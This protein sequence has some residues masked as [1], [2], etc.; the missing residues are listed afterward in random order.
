MKLRNIILL[1]LTFM[2]CAAAPAFAGEPDY[3]CYIG[4]WRTEQTSGTQSSLEIIDA[5]DNYMA[6]SFQYGQFAVTINNA[7]I[8]GRNVYGNYREAWEGGEF[9]VS[10][11]ITLNLGNNS[12][13]VNWE[14]YENGRGPSYSSFMFYNSRFVYREK[15]SAPKITEPPAPTPEPTPAYFDTSKSSIDYTKYLGSY[16][17]VEGDNVT[18]LTIKKIENETLDFECMCISSGSVVPM[19]YS[20]GRFKSETTAKS[21]GACEIGGR[22]SNIEY[23]F[24]FNEKSVQFKWWDGDFLTFSLSP[25]ERIQGLKQLWKYKINS[26]KSEIPVDDI[27]EESVAKPQEQQSSEVKQ[28]EGTQLSDN[29]LEEYILWFSSERE[30]TEND[31]ARH[32]DR[33]LTLIRNEIY[34]RHGRK[35]LTSWIQEYF[36]GCSWY[37]VNPDYNYDNEDSMLTALERHNLQVIV[38]YENSL[39]Q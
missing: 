37:S 7:K 25:Y 26:E 21:N 6:F 10:G 18:K 3:S 11:T 38:E 30:I 17:S 28:S 12:V 15:A 34:A 33:E 35:F 27:T 5:T 16:A 22:R 23:E 14:G 2:L 31:L 13:G 19:G 32:S 36:D 39:K 24:N 4:S 29:N 9:I 1:V 8:S 20:S